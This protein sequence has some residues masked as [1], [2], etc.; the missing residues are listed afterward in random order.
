MT[1]SNLDEINF[2]EVKSEL[3]LTVAN[4]LPV[5]NTAVKL[6]LEVEATGVIITIEANSHAHLM[7]IKNVTDS[8]QFVENIFKD[9]ISSKTF[10]KTGI[11]L[12]RCTKIE[13]R[14][15]NHFKLDIWHQKH[16]KYNIKIFKYNSIAL[17]M[18]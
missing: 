3:A 6:E 2:E 7:N 17:R 11:T 10:N 13:S 9:L 8:S 1:F 4:A 18:R 14:S 16:I 15:I 12:N 5:N